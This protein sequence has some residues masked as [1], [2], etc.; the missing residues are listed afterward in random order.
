MSRKRLG[1]K[2]REGR[3]NFRSFIHAP[4]F[5]NKR[6]GKERKKRKREKPLVELHLS[7]A[8][9][10]LISFLSLLEKKKRKKKERGGG[11]K[12]ERREGGGVLA[13]TQEKGEGKKRG[14]KEGRRD[15]DVECIR[16]RTLIQVCRRGRKK[17]KGKRDKEKKEKR[18][19]KRCISH[20]SSVHD[21]I[22][23]VSYLKRE[24]GKEKRGNAVV[25]RAFFLP[26]TRGGKK[27]K[28]K[29]RKKKKKKKEEERKGEKS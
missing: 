11:R 28:E 13:S 2:K 19:G 12:E 6:G 18:G 14:E 16:A 15:V 1:K 8:S 7:T 20:P 4:P 10:F 21:P 29:K 5:S 22:M 3:G 25:R 27:K 24:K 23:S 9:L 17:R 26:P